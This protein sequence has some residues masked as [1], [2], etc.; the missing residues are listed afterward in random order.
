MKKKIL[1]TIGGLIFLTIAAV[2]YVASTTIVAWNAELPLLESRGGLDRVSLLVVGD[3]GTQDEKQMMVA[4]AMSEYCQKHGGI[5]GIVLLGDNFYPDGVRSTD[6]PQ[7]QKAIWEPFGLPCL[8]G[9]DIFPILGNHD[10]KLNANAQ[11]EYSKINRRW[12][13][14]G[15]FYSV[16]FGGILE[17]AQLDSTRF[18]TWLPIP[19][20]F[21]ST[22][23]QQ[24][25]QSRARWKIVTSHHPVMSHCSNRPKKEDPLKL[26]SLRSQFCAKADVW[27]SGHVHLM[28][29]SSDPR[30]CAAQQFIVGSGGGD[31]Y[32]EEKCGSEALFK[33]SGYGFGVIDANFEQLK[34]RFI[35]LQGKPLYEW[36]RSKQ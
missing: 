6:D 10:R 32:G 18:D 23:R 26:A 17:L 36:G 2:G 20:G 12:R 24:F 11:V 15:R 21:I 3:T 27:L 19:G 5:I 1:W 30:L 9:L 31:L 14:P 29:H 33:R 28:E 34:F 13:M 22:I 35:D 7:W 4:E 8:D 16:Q 25:E